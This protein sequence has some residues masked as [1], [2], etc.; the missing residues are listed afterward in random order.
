MTEPLPAS[1]S[2]TMQIE[3]FDQ[4]TTSTMSAQDRRAFEREVLPH[5]ENLYGAAMRLTRDPTEA[6]DLVQDTTL[7]AWR[8]WGTFQSGANI[9]AW[10]FTILRNTFINS[11]HRKGRARN[12]SSELVSVAQSV[13]AS[14]AIGRAGDWV[15]R[16]ATGE[17]AI[18]LQN[19]MERIASAL[20]KLPAD[21]RL[22]VTLADL[23]GFSY[24][25]I[26]DM[27][28]CPIGTVMSRIHRGRKALHK[29]LF[30]HAVEL[31]M[32]D[33]ELAA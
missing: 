24:K 4:P 2:T 15:G 27:M 8:F 7:R 19:T 26:A 12:A 11:Y 6:E 21:F 16:S 29:L 25:E 14:A 23:E 17:E 30:G 20:A 3:L 22:A 10:L 5:Q 13:G 18:E 9:K 32:V 31:G 28:E 1:T 33:H